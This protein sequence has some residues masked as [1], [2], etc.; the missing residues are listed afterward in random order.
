MTVWT[1]TA[2]L[3]TGGH[4]IATDVAARMGVTL[5][6]RETLAT[7]AQRREP[8]LDVANADELEER[9]GG[10]RNAFAFS[11]AMISGAPEAFRELQLR[12]TLPDLGRA[13]LGEIARGPAVVLAHA[14]FAALAE[15]PGA[16]HVRIRAPFG[17]RVAEVRRRELLSDERARRAVQHDDQLHRNW[18]RT[19][20]HADLDDPAGFAVVVDASRLAP[21]RIVELL[22]AAGG[23]AGAD[24]GGRG[25]RAAL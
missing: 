11:A 25:T 6:D 15:H 18:V 24:V 21:D 2:Q 4:E 7:V 16:V 22:L 1:I 14:G 19:L 20:Y 3:G 5:L 23:Y 10:R 13:V 9:V 8:A 17:W 12:R